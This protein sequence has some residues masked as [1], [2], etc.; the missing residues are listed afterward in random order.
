MVQKIT[1]N[2]GNLA[3]RMSFWPYFLQLSPS[4]GVYSKL[5]SGIRN[6]SVHLGRPFLWVISG[7][8]KLKV[9]YL[10]FIVD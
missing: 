1:A 10:Y 6:F 4:S 2:L 3:P 7:P 5:A 9:T 8:R